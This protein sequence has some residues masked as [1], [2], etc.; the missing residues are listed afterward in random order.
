[1]ADLA[2]EARAATAI[3]EVAGPDTSRGP[4]TVASFTVTYDESGPDRTRPV[5]TAIVADLD[6]GRR[7]AAAC[8]NED[9]ARHAIRESLIGQRVHINGATF[10]P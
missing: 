10:I 5:R 1:M 7:T 2:Q 9:L 8:E 4:A 6:D 3:V